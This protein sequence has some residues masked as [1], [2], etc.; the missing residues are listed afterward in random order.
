MEFLSSLFGNIQKAF[1]PFIQGASS[2]GKALGGAVRNVSGIS[3]A[4]GGMAGKASGNQ[5]FQSFKPSQGTPIAPSSS[6]QSM[7]SALPGFNSTTNPNPSQG[8]NFLKKFLPSE[9]RSGPQNTPK[10]SGNDWMNQLFGKNPNQTMLGLG[11]N[12][13]G[14]LAAPKSKSVPDINSLE[15][16]QS[17]KSFQPGKMSPELEGAVNRSIQIK[18]DQEMKRINDI[19]KNLHPGFDPTTDTAYQREVSNLNRQQTIDR[20]D[21]I[22]LAGTQ[23]SSQEL[24][25]LKEIANYDISTIMLELGMSSEEAAQFKKSFSNIGS[26]FLQNGIYGNEGLI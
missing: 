14:D 4:I 13:I 19:Y 20:A 15:S 21:A 6:P 2:V 12:L 18:Q 16:I 11:M 10:E 24:E 5:A 22:A 1:T 3:N 17:L 8:V 9:T 26:M 25:K 7:A 23:A